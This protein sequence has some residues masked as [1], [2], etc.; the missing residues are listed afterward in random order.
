[1]TFSLLDIN[2]QKTGVPLKASA[3][4]GQPTLKLLQRKFATGSVYKAKA[5]QKVKERID[6]CLANAKKSSAFTDSLKRRGLDITI[7]RSAGIE[8]TELYI[9][10]SWSKSIFSADQ[11]GLSKSVLVETLQSEAG[12]IEQNGHKSRAGE[13]MTSLSK[14]ALLPGLALS[15]IRGLIASQT[16]G[17]QGHDVPQKKKKKKKKGPLL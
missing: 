9:I 17:D 6:D 1:M 2:G 7:L 16:G 3:L 15:V 11:L 13:Q 8:G 4:Y 14:D 5:K 10:D 12:L